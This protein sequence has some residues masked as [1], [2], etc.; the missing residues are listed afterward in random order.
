[1]ESCIPHS[2][3]LVWGQIVT[4]GSWFYVPALLPFLDS[5]P[6]I[7]IIIIII[8]IIIIIIIMCLYHKGAKQLCVFLSSQ[9]MGSRTELRYP[10]SKH[11]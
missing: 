4:S 10:A 2:I 5:F 3:S 9:F 11:F 8:V 6:I 7:I 1:M